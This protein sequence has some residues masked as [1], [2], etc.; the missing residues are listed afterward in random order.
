MKIYQWKSSLFYEEI[1]PTAKLTGLA[2]SEF[3]RDGKECFPSLPT[4]MEITGHNSINTIRKAIQELKDNS[5]MDV[6]H[7]IVKGRGGRPVNSYIFLG[8]NEQLSNNDSSVD[9]SVDSS[10]ELAD[11]LSNNDSEVTN[12]QKNK[13]TNKLSKM[14]T[15][16]LSKE[17]YLRQPL[18]DWLEYRK[19]LKVEKQWEYQYKKVKACNNP[20]IAVESSIGKGYKGVFDDN[21]CNSQNNSSQEKEYGVD[22]EMLEKLRGNK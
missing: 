13:K 14:E 17:E 5:L 9:S 4:I 8:V 22:Y 1:S 19:D 16:I 6:K 3:Y 20:E 2:I 21:N 18:S 12:K 10:I 11:E 15:F 7:K